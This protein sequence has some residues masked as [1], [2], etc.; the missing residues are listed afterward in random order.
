MQEGRKESNPHLV[1]TYP[2]LSITVPLTELIASKLHSK[3]GGWA[4]TAFEVR[5]RETE[6]QGIQGLD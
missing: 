6:A 4:V 5:G 1:S 3:H 2:E